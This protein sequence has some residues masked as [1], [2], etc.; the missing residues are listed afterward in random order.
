MEMLT[1]ARTPLASLP[2]PLERLPRLGESLGGLDLWVKRD[3]LTGLAFGGNKTRK[4]EY[5]LAAAQAAKGDCLVT[6]GAAQSNHCRQTAAAAA[7]SGMACTL[8]LRGDPPSAVN[9]NLLLDQLLGARL[10]WAGQRPLAEAQAA[11]IDDLRGAGKNPYAIPYGGSSPLG[12]AAYS[13]ALA[14]LLAQGSPP[15][16]IVH[17]SSSGGTQAGLLAGAAWTGFAGRILGISVDRTASDLRPA[18]LSLAE[19]TA[20]LLPS[21]RAIRLDDV[22]VRDEYLGE[23]YGV[24]SDLEQDAIERFA[25]LEGILLDPVYTGRAAGG[26]LDLA[27]RGEFQPGERVVFWHTGGGPALFA[28]AERLGRPL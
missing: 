20:A 11:A 10:V 14:E 9:G 6:C 22:L 25:R 17:A 28:Y 27:R 1:L 26:L 15:D 12:A 18:V 2:T 7:R 21:R 23:G 19:E 4:L 3:D 5:L 24:L 8:V 13:S 16:W